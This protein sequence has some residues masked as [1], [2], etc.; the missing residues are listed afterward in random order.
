MPQHRCGSSR[1]KPAARASRRIETWWVAVMSEHR[2]AGRR[3]LAG[4]VAAALTVLCGACGQSHAGQP[5]G[6]GPPAR[7]PA[8]SS[9]RVAIIV[10]ENKEAPLVIGSA[11]APYETA[12]ARRYG[13]ATRSYGVAHP[14]LPNYLALTSGST[15][16]VSSDC[17]DCEIAATNL[18]DQLETARISWGAYLE[19]YPG[20]C[21]TGAGSGGYAKK[22]DPFVYY[23]DVA[24]S[25]GRC[26]H[27]VGFA[28]LTRDLRRGTLPRFV[29]IT[30]SLCDDT[31]DCSVGVGDRFLADL[32]PA[33]IH[34][35]GPD[36]F[37]VITWDEGTTGAGCCAGTAAGGRIA[38]IVAGPGARRDARDARPV[39]HYGVLGTIEDALGLP[40]LGAAADPANGSLRS[41]LAHPP[42]LRS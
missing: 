10:M 27:L 23:D 19:G 4:A 11:A 2:H 39:D 30:P 37:L 6:L 40:R 33:L 21:F 32:V 13:L 28:A 25:P 5:L 12:L 15:H 20:N 38:T 16:G 41:L 8:S 14:S 36:G 24:R 29:W 18:V 42:P 1:C 3:R 9:S 26:R 31:H 17:T 22:H 35:L 34:E 7:L